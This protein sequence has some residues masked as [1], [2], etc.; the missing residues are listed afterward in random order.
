MPPPLVLLGRAPEGSLLFLPLI[1]PNPVGSGFFRPDGLPAVAAGAVGIGEER[2]PGSR[3]QEERFPLADEESHRRR[4]VGFHGGRAAAAVTKAALA[5]TLPTRRGNLARAR[6]A[7]AIREGNGP[8]GGNACLLDR[9]SHAARAA[10]A[11][12]GNDQAEDKS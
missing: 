1:Y 9:E 7:V 6:G 2:L 5:A 3:G 12:R 10:A 8:R 11:G 4:I